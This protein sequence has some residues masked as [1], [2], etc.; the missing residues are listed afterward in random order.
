MVP[1]LNDRYSDKWPLTQL[2]P[3]DYCTWQKS[4]ADLGAQTFFLPSVFSWSSFFC[5][6]FNAFWNW[7]KCGWYLCSFRL[8]A[9]SCAGR[10][11]P[12]GVESSIIQNTH[13][14][15]D[16]LEFCLQ[17]LLLQQCIIDSSREGVEWYH[18]TWITSNRSES[19]QCGLSDGE[20]ITFLWRRKCFAIPCIVRHWGTWCL[21]ILSIIDVL[22]S[23]SS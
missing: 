19:V 21:T 3:F 5:T 17:V 23:P 4:L 9:N 7:F 8:V 20:T 12:L 1:Q 16:S 6:V 10:P 14:F 15:Y 2:S 11:C 18:D 22:A 13:H